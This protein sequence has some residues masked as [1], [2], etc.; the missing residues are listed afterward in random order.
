MFF[1]DAQFYWE[2]DFFVKKEEVKRYALE[3]EM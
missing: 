2:D 3:L 1:Q